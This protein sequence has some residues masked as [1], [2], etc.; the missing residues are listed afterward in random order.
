LTIPWKTLSQEIYSDGAKEGVQLLLEHTNLYS[1]HS[2]YLLL[3][4]EVKTHF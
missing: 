3:K 1:W 4:I 2:W